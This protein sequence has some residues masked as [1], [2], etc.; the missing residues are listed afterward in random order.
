M[1]DDEGSASASSRSHQACRKLTKAH[2]RDL[3][4]GMERSPMNYARWL[5]AMAVGAE[6]YHMVITT[7][8]FEQ[9][10]SFLSSWTADTEVEDWDGPASSILTTFARIFDWLLKTSEPN[11]RLADGRRLMLE[12]KTRLKSVIETLFNVVAKAPTDL[13]AHSSVS[14]DKATELLVLVASSGT[15]ALH[16]A[17]I[18]CQRHIDSYHRLPSI[19]EMDDS[20]DDSLYEMRGHLTKPDPRVLN[21]TIAVCKEGLGP[22]LQTANIPLLLPLAL[23]AAVE[24]LAFDHLVDLIVVFVSSLWSHSN[25]ECHT[26]THTYDRLPELLVGILNVDLSDEQSAA[27]ALA[28]DIIPAV[29]S[30]L[31]FDETLWAQFFLGRVDQLQRELQQMK[32]RMAS[33]MLLKANEVLRRGVGI[34]RSLLLTVDVCAGRVAAVK[35]LSRKDIWLP[36]VDSEFLDADI[37]A[38]YCQLVQVLIPPRS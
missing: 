22:N 24:A 9:Y 31:P 18:L 34:L 32:Q 28:R 2:D 15:N 17:F 38:Q 13:G 33:N 20:S 21:L 19:E 12:N 4:R 3:L 26:F 27:V 29:R 36:E 30:N 14:V 8:I 11:S 35:Q 23:S 5:D 10:L 16:H 37:Q 1:R 25:P 7:N 6:E